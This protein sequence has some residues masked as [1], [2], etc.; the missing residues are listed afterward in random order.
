MPSPEELPGNMVAVVSDVPVSRGRIT[1]AEFQHA[2][3]LAAGRNSVPKPGGNGYERLKRDTLDYLLEGVW[4]VGE[5][6]EMGIVVTRS[7]VAHELALIKKQSFKS[8][9]EYRRFLRESHYT[10]RD[11]NERVEVQML[12]FRLQKRLQERIEREARNKFEEQRAIREFVTEFNERWRGRTVCAPEYAT[13]RCSNGPLPS[14][15]T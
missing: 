9:A 7:E 11:M 3:V 8:E 13:E 1:K 12:S 5:A 15:G 14:G 6:A 4:I 10:R 2:L